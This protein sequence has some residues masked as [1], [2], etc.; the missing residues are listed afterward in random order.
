MLKPFD[1]VHSY[2]PLV[3]VCQPEFTQGGDRPSM[4]G[5]MRTSC[6][7][8]AILCW[9]PQLRSE[10]QMPTAWPQTGRT[11]GP[12]E[13]R[14]RCHPAGSVPLRLSRLCLSLFS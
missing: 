5:H 1:Y 3:P 11:L 10:A 6:V 7:P 9:C 4:V 14:Y 2:I 13:S 8:V 12:E